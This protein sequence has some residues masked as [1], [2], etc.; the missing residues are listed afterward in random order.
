MTCDD[1]FLSHLGI[2]VCWSG[3]FKPGV[4]IRTLVSGRTEASQTVDTEH[5]PDM[6]VSA[7]GTVATE[8]TIIPGTVSHLGLGVDVEE[9]AFFVVA[10]IES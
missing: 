5:S 10:G 3:Q 2:L 1:Y 7:V 8:A 6:S 4:G 9:G